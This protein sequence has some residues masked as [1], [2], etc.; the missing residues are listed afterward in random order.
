MSRV[1]RLAIVAAIAAASLTVL[2]ASVA[3]SAQNKGATGKLEVFSWWTSGSE[4]AALEQL[5]AATKKANPGIDIVN[6]AVAGGA[7]TNAKQVLATRLAGGDVPETWQTQPG[8]EL[9]DY[10]NQRVTE[11][12]DDLYAK[13]GWAKVVPPSIL[14]S[15]SFN[16]HRYAV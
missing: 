11:P 5:F 14:K 9:N 4:N 7:G 2:G 3:D 6:A 8:G 12:I 1:R 16:G 13:N 15:V 10:V